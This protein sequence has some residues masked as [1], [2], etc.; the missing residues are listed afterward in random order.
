MFS[1]NVCYYA[2]I[3]VEIHTEEMAK[4]TFVNEIKEISRN[5]ISWYDGFSVGL[6]FNVGS[7]E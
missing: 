7:V 1:V 5:Y 3:T 2:N 6:L 4:V